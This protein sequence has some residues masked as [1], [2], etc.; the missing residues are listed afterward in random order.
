M[1]GLCVVLLQKYLVTARHHGFKLLGLPL[2]AGGDD[3]VLK[4]TNLHAP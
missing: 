1:H 3:E 4:L 2:V